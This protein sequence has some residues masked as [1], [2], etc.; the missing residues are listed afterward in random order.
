M[1]LWLANYLP[2]GSDYSWLC[3]QSMNCPCSGVGWTKPT[4]R[5]WHY[6]HETQS[7]KYDCGEDQTPPLLP[8]TGR[9]VRSGRFSHHHELVKG[10]CQKMATHPVMD[11]TRGRMW[12]Q[13]H[14]KYLTSVLLRRFKLW[15]LAMMRYQSVYSAVA[16]ITLVTFLT[17]GASALWLILRSVRLASLPSALTESSWNHW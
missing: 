12:Q 3:W 9:S 16:S 17:A 2:A 14:N 7:M 11:A 10:M 6:I 1:A 5:K 4:T 15:I 13:C 8:T